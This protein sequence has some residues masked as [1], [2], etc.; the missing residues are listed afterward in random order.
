MN[1]VIYQINGKIVLFLSIKL[2]RVCHIESL[3]EQIYFNAV[4]IVEKIIKICYFIQDLN[5]L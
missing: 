1:H 2:A 5:H 3:A 4:K